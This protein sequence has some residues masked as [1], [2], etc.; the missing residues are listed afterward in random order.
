MRTLAIPYVGLLQIIEF[1]YLQP[2]L[3]QQPQ[4]LDKAK[5]GI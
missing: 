3:R 5:L 1:L 2:Q 4:T